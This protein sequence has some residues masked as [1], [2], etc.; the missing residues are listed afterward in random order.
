M[1]RIII[2]VYAVLMLGGGFM[3]YAKAHSSGSLIAGIVSAVLLG[4]AWFLAGQQP[5][6]GFGLG[7][8]VAVGLVILFANR[9]RE[10]AA[11]I[12]PGT[13]GSNIGLAALSGIV[14]IVLIV[15]LAKARS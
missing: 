14:A 11:G 2:A 8:A 4:V 10:I 15:A 13:T 7:A 9:V 6:L 12:T 3:G 5:R 1:A